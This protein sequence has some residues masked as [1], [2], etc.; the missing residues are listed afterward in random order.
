MG[1]STPIASAIILIGLVTFMGVTFVSLTYSI[2]QLTILLNTLVKENSNVQ[3]EL[4]IVSINASSIEFYVK[5]TGSKTIFLENRGFNWNS[6]I[7][8]YRNNTWHSYLIENYRISEI[9]IQNSAVTF[10]A[11]AHKYINPGEEAKIIASLPEYAPR[12]PY[13]ETVI[14]VFFSHY[15]VSAVKEGV[16]TA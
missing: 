13:N 8:A 12:I 7:I 4:N 5:N 10:N 9:R 15:G 16:R 3:L 1:F 14:V 6:V 2:N 11:S